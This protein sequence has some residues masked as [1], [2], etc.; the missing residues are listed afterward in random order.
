MSRWYRAY[1]GTVTDAKLAEAAMVADVSRAVSIAAWHCLLESASAVNNCGSYQTS[2][3]RVSII[4]C[5]PT[6]AVEALFA[7]Y[8]EIGLIG[9]GAILAWK[10]RQYQGAG[11]TD[12]SGKNYT[13]LVAP[14]NMA[15]VK[16]GHSKNPWARL[17]G[18][19][20]GHPEKLAVIATIITDETGDRWLLDAFKDCAAVGEWVTPNAKMMAL[21]A[22]LKSKTLKTRDDVERWL[23]NYVAG[24][25]ATTYTDSPSDD[26]R[27]LDVEEVFTGCQSLM[28]D[29]GLTVPRDLTAVRRQLIRFRIR[30]YP[31]AD[32]Q[33]VF[34]KCRDSPFLRGDKGRTPLNFDWLFKKANFRPSDRRRNGATSA[35]PGSGARF[36]TT[37]TGNSIRAT[38][39][40]GSLRTGARS[41]GGSRPSFGSGEGGNGTQENARHTL[42]RRPQEEGQHRPR[43]HQARL[44]QRALR[45]AA[46]ALPSQEHSRRQ[47]GVDRPVRRNWPAPRDRDAGRPR[48]RRQA[49]ARGGREY[50]GL[51]NYYFIEMMPKGSDLERAYG[52]R[53]GS[54]KLD[55][56]PPATRREIRFAQLDE[57]LPRG[58]E[59]RYWTQKILL[60]HFGLDTVHPLIDRLVNYKF[61]QWKLPVAGLIAGREDFRKLEYILRGLFALADGALPDRWRQAA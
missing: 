51:Y 39:F 36:H 37:R 9:D 23:A 22:A 5:E 55:N 31:L 12:G 29:L 6:A 56:I 13:Y 58:S 25:V 49:D 28:S 59:E 2:A 3:R 60:D 10:K 35:T 44:R 26:E 46:R 61:A 27:A 54:G 30:Q 20:T 41:S 48:P 19:Q 32:F 21:I 40:T 52:G 43:A 7:A 53:T 42:C 34:A 17:I 16:I 33:T 11:E 4:L 18:I 47:G 38:T 50:V 15:A 24:D 1:E 57:L 8:A 45:R 14:E